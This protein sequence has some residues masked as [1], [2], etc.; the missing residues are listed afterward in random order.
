MSNFGSFSLDLDK[1]LY[2]VLIVILQQ[3]ENNRVIELPRPLLKVHHYCDWITQ[4]YDKMCAYK[5]VVVF[6]T[7]QPVSPHAPGKPLK[8]FSPHSYFSSILNPATA[9]PPTNPM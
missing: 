5:H 9:H 8:A 4:T 6:P 3:N 2:I 1:D 7:Y